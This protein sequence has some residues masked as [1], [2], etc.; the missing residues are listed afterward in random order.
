MLLISKEIAPTVG[1]TTP[2]PNNK[3]SVMIVDDDDSIL[4]S[5]SIVRRKYA[6]QTYNRAEIAVAQA[7]ESQPDVI[8]LD[9][10]KR[11]LLGISRDLQV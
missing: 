4:R 6:V 10:R 3:P 1:T 5:L 9:A 8:M 7:R 2:M 11:R